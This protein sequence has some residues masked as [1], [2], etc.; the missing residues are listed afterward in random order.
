MDTPAD[1][2]SRILFGFS[3]SLLL[4]VALGL[5]SGLASIDNCESDCISDL[6]VVAALLLLAM[7]SMYAC[8]ALR[9][10]IAVPFQKH[11][12]SIFLNESEAD[13]WNRLEGERID[14]DD[15]GR[16]SDSWAKLEVGLGMEESE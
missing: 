8:W 3:A 2:A 16:M 15:I 10:S 7:V 4:I 5:R 13:L 11:L 12:H 14:S 1:R 9:T 6:P